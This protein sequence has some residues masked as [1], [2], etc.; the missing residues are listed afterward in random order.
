MADLV[1]VV[2]PVYN[3]EEYLEACLDSIIAQSYYNLEV[4]LVDDGSTDISG[5][6]CDQ[7]AKKDGRIIVLHQK[8]AGVSVARNRGIDVASGRYIMF[9]DADDLLLSESVEC[10]LEILKNSDAECAMGSLRTFLRDGDTEEASH[11]SGKN[12]TCVTVSA[13]DAICSMLYERSVHGGPF[14]KLY[15]LDAVKHIRFPEDIK[16][17]EDLQYNYH[18]FR[19]LK[20]VTLTDRAVYWYR[21]REGGAMASGF[22]HSRIDGL[23]ATKRVFD[24]ALGKAKIEDAAA[25]R[26]FMEAVYIGICIKSRKIFR[27]E[28]QKCVQ[29]M[30]RFSSRVCRDK[31]V[32]GKHR[33]LA[34]IAVVSPGLLFGLFTL[35]RLLRSIVRKDGRVK[36]YNGITS[37]DEL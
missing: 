13:T 2:V 30:K 37:K 10:L 14:P 3:V 28:Y 1:T 33:V 17:A 20:R 16:Y 23:I 22:S 4:I 25:S 15:L 19:A 7:Y 32:K 34:L 5:K 35:K 11:L 18:A 12:S 24:D 8:N 31:N 6:I 26:Y 21:M 27:K 9:V 29:V 36:E